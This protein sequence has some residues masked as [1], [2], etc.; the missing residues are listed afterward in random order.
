MRKI[1][2]ILFLGSLLFSSCQY[3][4]KQVPSKE[5]LLNEQLKSI[6]W[7]VVDEFPSV[8]N[9]DS[10]ADKTQKQQC[11]F[12]FLTQLIQ[13]KLSADTLSVLYPTLD[14]I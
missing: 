9:C 12:E 1:I 13:Q 6:N 8:A 4:D 7:K 11:F 5:Q 3:F 14:T 10:I 2:G